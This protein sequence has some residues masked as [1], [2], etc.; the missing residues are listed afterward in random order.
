MPGSGKCVMLNQGQ[1]WSSLV[2]VFSVAIAPTVRA[3]V[4]A[5][6]C[7]FRSAIPLGLAE[8]RHDL[9]SETLQIHKNTAPQSVR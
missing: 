8:T 5:S 3:E 4:V 7:S 6:D 2:S 1:Y 9:T